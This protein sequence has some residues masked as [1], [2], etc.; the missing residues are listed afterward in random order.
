MA[1][2]KAR[3]TGHRKVYIHNTL[4]NAAFFL[5]NTIER[6]IKEEEGFEPPDPVI[7]N[8]LSQA[9]VTRIGTTVPMVGSLAQN[10]AQASISRRR[11]SN[12][13]PRR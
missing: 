13:S 8:V 4:E 5:K 12:R 3:V 1:K 6:K 11:F 2:V 10:S 9:S 7:T